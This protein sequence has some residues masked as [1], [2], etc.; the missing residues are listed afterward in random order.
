MTM[1]RMT[2]LAIFS[3]D[4]K[5]SPSTSGRNA[6]T[7]APITGPSQKCTPPNTTAARV[8]NPSSV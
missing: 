4:S 2:P 8:T 5:N 6:N 3:P 7:N 1:M